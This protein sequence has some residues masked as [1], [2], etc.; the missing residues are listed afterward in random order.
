MTSHIECQCGLYGPYSWSW[1]GVMPSGMA[2]LPPGWADSYPSGRNWPLRTALW[3]LLLF[4]LGSACVAC[5][6][7]GRSRQMARAFYGP[8]SAL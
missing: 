3:F 6:S 7:S 1:I 4:L 2:L 5:K 8:T